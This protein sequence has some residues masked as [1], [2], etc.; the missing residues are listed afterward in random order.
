MTRVAESRTGSAVG[1]ISGGLDST[2]VAAHMIAHYDEQRFLFCDYG[3][4]TL[5]RELAAFNQLRE[6][7]EPTDAQ[8]I[9]MTW[10]QDVGKS[11]LFVGGQKLTRENRKN[12]YVP[13][14]NAAMLS[15]AVALAES[16]EADAVLIGSTGGDTTC[17][18]NSPE[19]IAAFQGVVDTGTMTSKKINIVA[20]L[21][22]LGKRQVIEHGLSLDAPFELSWSCHNNLGQVAC[23]V[24]SNCESR[25][26][27]FAE[28]GLVDPVQ[29]EAVPFKRS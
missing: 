5:S 20:P 23:G 22:Q 27:A 14:R 6:F 1:L 12:E 26:N 18:D 28:I 4:K 15:A 13:F 24:C 25:Y 8:V 10:L 9:D 17:P 7:F 21:I 29:Y 11:A 2:V 19:F 3:Q 16:V